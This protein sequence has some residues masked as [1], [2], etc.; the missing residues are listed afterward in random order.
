MPIDNE[1]ENTWS[2]GEVA[3][4][5]SAAEALAAAREAAE[6]KTVQEF[7]EAFETSGETKEEK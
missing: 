3:P 7:A 1:F 6:V 5:V 4:H 2:E